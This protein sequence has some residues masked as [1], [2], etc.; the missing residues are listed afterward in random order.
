[1]NDLRNPRQTLKSGVVMSSRSG[2]LALSLGLAALVGFAP[3][4]RA[5]AVPPLVTPPQPIA[6]AGISTVPSRVLRP[7]DDRDTVVLTGNTPAKADAAFDRGLVDPSLQLGHMF[8]VLQRS[9][10]QEFALEAFNERQHDPNSPDY[11]HWLSAAE[12]G[13]A[14][15]PSDADI[16]AVTSWLKSHGLEVYQVNNGRVTIEFSGSV[17][18]IQGAFHVQMHNYLGDATLQIANDRDPQI[19]SA[20]GSVVGGIVGLD[21]FPIPA[22][23]HPGEYVRRDHATGQLV[24]VPSAQHPAANTPQ[25]EFGFPVGTGS[26]AVTREFVA[27]YDF[28]TIYNSLPLWKATTPINGSG[29]SIAIVGDHDVNLNDIANFRKEFGLPVNTPTVVHVGKDPG[30]SSIENTLDLE[31]AGAAAPEAKITLYVPAGGNTVG[32][33]VSAIGY[34]VDNESAP[35]MSSSYGVCELQLGSENASV[36]KI[37]QQGATEGISIVVSAGDQGSA[38]C[39]ARSADT[40]DNVGLQ[41]N[42]FA[43]SPYITAVGGT[44]L[45]WSYLAN[46]LK[47]YWKTT[48]NSTTHASAKG[49]IPEIAWNVNCASPILL[50]FFVNSSGKP[51]FTTPE[52][53]CNTISKGPVNDTNYKPLL[54]VGGGSGGVSRCTTSNGASGSTCSG[55]YAKP[56]WQTGTGVP[57]DG[58]RDVPDVALFASYGW[59]DYVSVQGAPLVLSSEILFC[60][61]GGGTACV[62][63]NDI[64]ITLQANG[65]TSAAAPYWAGIMAMVVQKQG[66]AR[67]GLA[68]Q[69]LY[70]LAN[71]ETLSSCNSNKVTNGNTCTFYDITYG[72]NAQVC[73][74]GDLNCVTKTSGDR[75]GILDGYNTTT[76]YDL[77]TGLGSVNITNLVNNWSSS[78]PIPTVSVTPTSLAFVATAV[79]SASATQVVTV[80]NTGMVAVTLKSGGITFTGT[81]ASSFKETAT[82]CGAAL[83]IG[84]NCTITVEFKPA[85]A[86]S[87][88]GKLSIADNAAGSPQTVSL[89]G[90]GG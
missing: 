77:A 50:D 56:S 19:P 7:V 51:L 88:T 32:G 65:G 74:T 6:S 71:K 16:A 34:I 30:G 75:G 52:A 20:L 31:M 55:G 12:F 13:L 82:T 27:P 9:Q 47:D 22:T 28:A 11:H 8:L 87:L 41:V 18:Q 59:P 72:S 45:G 68:N 54:T 46:G 14:Y 89:K 21:N 3:A 33:Y 73:Y 36:N 86:G 63:T 57:A 23:S 49:Y 4:T 66:G 39:S 70:K 67:Q 60:Y 61:S 35:I 90:T 24:P 78:A 5:Q 81:N 42:G 2:I 83:S 69:T 17:G 76:G 15:G 40:P 58:K 43:S 79:G 10:Q 29:V 64:D 48:N 44:D 1:M 84:A 25:P 53:V 85:A 62:Y 80:K 26:N 38:G 37:Y